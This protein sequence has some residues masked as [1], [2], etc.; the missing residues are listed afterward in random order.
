[1]GVEI[2]RKMHGPPRTY[3]RP[4]EAFLK[5]HEKKVEAE[6]LEE[7]RLNGWPSYADGVIWFVNPDDFAETVAE[8]LPKRSLQTVMRTAFG[9]LVLVGEGHVFYLHV[10]YARLISVATVLNRYLDFSVDRKYVKGVMDGALAAK[11]KAKLGELS[12]DEMFMFE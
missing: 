12:P 11:A 4:S 6:L 10:H 5:K 8:W 9:D 1:M 7:W 3:A 2:F